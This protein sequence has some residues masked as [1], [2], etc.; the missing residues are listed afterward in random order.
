[1]QVCNALFLAFGCGGCITGTI[2][3]TYS[4]NQAIA[5]HFTICRGNRH[6]GA[7]ATYLTSQ[8]G[9]RF[10]IS[11]TFMTGISGAAAQCTTTQGKN[12]GAG[13]LKTLVE[14]FN[15]GSCGLSRFIAYNFLQLS[16]QFLRKFKGCFFFLLAGGESAQ[17]QQSAGGNE[18]ETFHGK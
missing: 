2:S 8:F 3:C 14:S 17:G 5:V 10:C 9:K 6:A 13:I 4:K 16:G 15:T 1:M 18:E 11:I 12:M 7:D